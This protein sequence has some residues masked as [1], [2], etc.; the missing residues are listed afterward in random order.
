LRTI[1]L[2]GEDLSKG[3]SA[4]GRRSVM[5]L[6]LAGC[7]SA[8][9]NGGM[10]WFSQWPA[11]APGGLDPKVRAVLDAAGPVAE[12]RTKP[13]GGLRDFFGEQAARLPKLRE[14]VA[15]IE[16]RT[17]AGGVPVRLYRPEGEGPLPVLL[18]F[19][20]GGWVLGDLESHD[21]VCRSL[22]HRGGVLVL[23][24]HYRLAPETRFPGPVDD[25][26]DVLRWVA[27]HAP[28]LGADGSRVA[29]GGDSAGGQIAAAI[30]IRE[31]KRVRFQLLIY[32]VTDASF[33]T[34]SYR[35]FASGF[36]L[37]RAN[38]IWFWESYLA[39]PSDASDPLASP[40]RAK[41]LHGVPSAFIATAECDVL[42][43]EGEAY[44]RRLHEAGVRLRCVRYRN[45][46]HGFVR[47]G[48]VYS[49]ADRALTDLAQALRDGLR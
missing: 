22:A 19:H 33:E 43:D 8:G 4:M 34:A 7:A 31:R 16:D 25:G 6:I 3:G 2:S 18:Y 30:A 14:P 41:D 36:G 39:K 35:E 17:V 27:D 28:E 13:L 38:M 12:F 49:Q 44:A 23:S 32:P 48:A 37:T 11:E 47:M 9:Q 10:A 15:K 40:L 42:R 46:N 5:V 45:L 21:D 20:G 29:V 1:V 26:S 24:V